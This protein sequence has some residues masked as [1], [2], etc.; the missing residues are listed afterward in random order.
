MNRKLRH[1]LLLDFIKTKFAAWTEESG[2]GMVQAASTTRQARQR[3]DAIQEAA[4]KL[5]TGS[6]APRQGAFAIAYHLLTII[7]QRHMNLIDSARSCCADMTG[8]LGLPFAEAAQAT[9]FFS[10]RFMV[11]HSKNELNLPDHP[12]T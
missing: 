2:Q 12:E 3:G 5:G 4:G 7:W 8:P 6:F 11:C 1:D 9:N 10:L